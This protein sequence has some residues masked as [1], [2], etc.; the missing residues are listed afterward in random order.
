MCII[1]FVLWEW[2]QWHAK[3][4][5]LPQSFNPF[6]PFNPQPRTST[7]DRLQPRTST[8]DFNHGLQPRTSTTDFNHDTQP[9]YS[10]TTLQSTDE[11]FTN[12]IAES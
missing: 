5:Q 7:T 2:L 10:T 8:T 4:R 12:V 6:N 9:R 3:V 1:A 11:C